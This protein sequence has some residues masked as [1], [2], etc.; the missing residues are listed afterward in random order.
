MEQKQ[1]S[2]PTPAIVREDNLD[3]SELKEASLKS[4]ISTIEVTD[5]SGTNFFNH[6]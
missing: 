1:N 5:F 3:S 6:G 2:S 4:K